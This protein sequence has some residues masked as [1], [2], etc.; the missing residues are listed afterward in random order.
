[1]IS[2]SQRWLNVKIEVS[3]HPRAKTLQE[4][5]HIVGV[6]T[7]VFLDTGGRERADLR[8]YGFVPPAE[9]IRRMR[10]VK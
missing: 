1:V 5:F 4:R 8:I 3:T 7:I 9:L 10:M 2:E 6:P